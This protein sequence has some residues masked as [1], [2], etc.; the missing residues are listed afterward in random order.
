MKKK[1]TLTIT[2]KRSCIGRPEKQR[3]VV[4]GLGLR[5]I[6]SSVVLPDIPEIRGMVNK[7]PHLVEVK[8]S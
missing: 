7:I 5:G 2:L 4:R 3:L 1:K 6:N 8:E